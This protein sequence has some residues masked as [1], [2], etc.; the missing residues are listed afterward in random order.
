[1]DRW[2]ND[3]H[4]S[5]VTREPELEI[6]REWR[7]VGRGCTVEIDIETGE[8]L[9]DADIAVLRMMSG[10]TFAKSASLT[11]PS[12]RRVY[13]DALNRLITEYAPGG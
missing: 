9:T 4:P 11:L 7:E 12:G 10:A 8:E 13:G 3:R 1:M 5:F 6:G 2:N